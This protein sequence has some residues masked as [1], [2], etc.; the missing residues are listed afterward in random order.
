LLFFCFVL[1]CFNLKIALSLS[2]P[3]ALGCSQSQLT[4]ATHSR[5]PSIQAAAAST[6][7]DVLLLKGVGGQK[8]THEKM[9]KSHQGTD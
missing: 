3:T 8:D 1:F 2:L 5:A 4:A 6:R 9:R 7:Q